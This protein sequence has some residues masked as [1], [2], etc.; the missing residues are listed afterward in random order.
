MA[1]HILK[2]NSDNHLRDVTTNTTGHYGGEFS[3][4]G[5]NTYSFMLDRNT[6]KLHYWKN[7]TYD[8]TRSRA[9]ANGTYYAAIG[10]GASS[11]TASSSTKSIIRGINSNG[12]ATFTYNPDT[13]WN[14][15]TSAQQGP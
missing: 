6:K 7:G 12:T 3:A 1:D 11:N 10:D 8:S 5:G 15:L 2:I 4:S 13:L 9:L 14:N